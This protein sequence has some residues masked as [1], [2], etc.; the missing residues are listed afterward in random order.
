MKAQEYVRSLMGAIAIGTLC[1]L[2]TAR[3][4]A[5]DRAFVHYASAGN[6][7]SS[8]TYLNDPICNANPKAALMVT[9]T[10]NPYNQGNVADTHNLGVWYDN[11]SRRWAIFHQDGAA[12]QLNAAFNVWGNSNNTLTGFV[13]KAAA[14][15]GKFTYIDNP[16]TNWNPYAVL[17]VTQVWNA[18]GY[19]GTYN[20]SPIA[21]SYDSGRGQWAIQNT[22]SRSMPLGA[23]FFVFVDTANLHKASPSNTFGNYTSLDDSWAITNNS[24][25]TFVTANATPNGSFAALNSHAAGVMYLGASG[26]WSIVN[27][28]GA[29]MPVGANFNTKQMFAH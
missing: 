22:V 8:W 28:D 14:P 6:I 29:E 1:L 27:L 17:Y 4:N 15:V 16:N 24:A 2:T 21:V 13:H 5:Q 18:F 9:P 25:L 26:V 11:S 12:M 7:T 3:V 23:A 10:V 20:D 19:G